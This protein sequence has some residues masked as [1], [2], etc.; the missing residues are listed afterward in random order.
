MAEIAL[1]PGLANINK[2]GSYQLEGPG[3]GDDGEES[4]TVP[5]LKDAGPFTGPAYINTDIK[6]ELDIMSENTRLAIEN[7]ILKQQNQALTM[8][9]AFAAGSGPPP[10]WADPAPG[11]PAGALPPH[12]YP[13]WW[14]SAMPMMSPFGAWDWHGYGVGPRATLPHPG[15]GRRKQ[16]GGGGRMRASTDPESPTHMLAHMTSDVNCDSPQSPGAEP[17]GPRTTV[18]I[19]NIPNNYS[20]AQLLKLLDSEGFVGKYDFVYLPMDF[21]ADANLGYAF[22]NLVDTEQ[23]LKFWKIFEGFSNWVVSSSKVCSVS[24]SAPHQGLKAH[25]ERYRN[26]SVM[27]EGVPDEYKPMVLLAGRRVAFPV[28]TRAIKAPRARLCR[29]DSNGS[30]AVAVA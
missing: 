20:R 3:L 24:W 16:N 19:R 2:F 6:G 14:H 29:E 22:V 12:F 25:V 27:H 7:D 1:P 30:E 4:D 18:M 21:K 15:N 17:Q 8:A 9:Q 5:E 10:N 26:S 28:P 11:S 23:A 13:A